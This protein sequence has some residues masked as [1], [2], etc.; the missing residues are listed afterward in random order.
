[1]DTPPPGL[2]P[3]IDILKCSRGFENPL[4]RTKEAAEKV[5]RKMKCVPSAAKA[6][7]VYKHLRTG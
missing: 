4:P 7:R 1:L 6:G 3:S 5:G 2:K